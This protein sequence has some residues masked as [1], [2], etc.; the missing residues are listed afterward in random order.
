MRWPFLA[1]YLTWQNSRPILDV[2]LL[3]KG[4]VRDKVPT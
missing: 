1:D 2:R 3:D 4:L